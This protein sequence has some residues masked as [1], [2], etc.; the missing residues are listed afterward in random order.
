MASTGELLLHFQAA[1]LGIDFSTKNVNPGGFSF[2]VSGPSKETSRKFKLEGVKIAYAPR[3]ASALPKDTAFDSKGTP[4]DI[5][6]GDG[7]KLALTLILDSVA[8]KD[9]IED[10][11]KIED[12]MIEALW[13]NREKVW[14]GYGKGPKTLDECRQLYKGTLVTPAVLDADGKEMAP[15]RI[16][17]SIP[18]WLVFASDFTLSSWKAKDKVNWRVDGCKFKDLSPDFP[19][20]Q[21]NVPTLLKISSPDSEDLEFVPVFVDPKATLDA[22][23]DIAED[24]EGTPLLRRV[25]PADI[26]KDSLADVVIDLVGLNVGAKNAIKTKSNTTEIVFSREPAA[27]AAP[28]RGQEG[29]GG[30]CAGVHGRGQAPRV[31]VK[32]YVVAP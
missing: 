18:G 27:P 14:P 22:P 6:Y 31:N 24:D 16:Y 17:T 21:T 4:V 23:G 30:G 32:N 15:P 11:G 7:E 19:W 5:K 25:T 10:L 2:W 9:A 12:I 26:T 1:A 3:P 8:H 13:A 28:P 29:G 20:P